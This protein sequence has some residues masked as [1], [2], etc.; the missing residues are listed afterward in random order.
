MT[1]KIANEI[2]EALNN[3]GLVGKRMGSGFC[4]LDN[5]RDVQFEYSSN[6]V[7][8]YFSKIEKVISEFTTKYEDYDVT[9]RFR[10]NSFSFYVKPPIEEKEPV[11]CVVEDEAVDEAVDEVVD[12]VVDEE[13]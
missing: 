2:E 7:K 10:N 3:E 11:K 8:E 1:L 12:E 13:C 5:S 4:F 9:I 6:E